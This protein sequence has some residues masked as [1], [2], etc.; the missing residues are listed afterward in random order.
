[1]CTRNKNDLCQH[2][3]MYN[4]PTQNTS[5]TKSLVPIPVSLGNRRHTYV[6]VVLAPGDS[7]KWLQEE[8]R[9]YPSPCWEVLPGVLSSAPAHQKWRLIPTDKTASHFLSNLLLAYTQWPHFLVLCPTHHMRLRVQSLHQISTLGKKI[10]HGGF[11][12]IYWQK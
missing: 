10:N 2:S 1:M 9:G 4:T 8:T 5:K 3:S 6:V 12:G 7:V 11:R